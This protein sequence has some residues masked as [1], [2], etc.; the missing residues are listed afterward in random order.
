MNTKKSL[1]ALLASVM[2]VTMAGLMTACTNEDNASNANVDNLA[3]KIIG[4]WIG[5]DMDGQEMMTNEKRVVTFVSATKAYVSA[6][7][8]MQDI[9][10]IWSSSIEASVAIDGNKMTVI[11][12]PDELTTVEEEFTVTAIDDNEFTANCK[13]TRTVDGIEQ[14]SGIINVRHTKVTADYSQAIVGIWE[15]HCTSANSVFDDGQEHRWEYRADGSYVYYCKDAN[16]RWEAKDAVISQ[17]FV[18]GNLLCTRWQNIGEN[19]NRE[20]WEISIDGNTMNWTALRQNDD[21]TT[22][23]A[24][25]TM[26]KV[27]DPGVMWP[28]AIDETYFPDEVFRKNLLEYHDKDQDGKLSV[29]EMEKT[30]KVEMNGTGL[31]SLKGIELFSELNFLRIVGGELTSVDVSKNTKLKLLHILNNQLTD[32]DVSHNPVLGNIDLSNNQLTKIDIS[33]N[34]E[35]FLL[36][37]ADNKVSSIDLSNNR[38]IK[39]LNVGNNLLTELDVTGLSEMY[40]C[41]CYGNQLTTLDVTGCD[42][43]MIFTIYNNRIKGD[44]MTALINSMPTVK[45]G[46]FEVINKQNG[47]EQNVI[48]DEQIAAAQAKGWTVEIT[49]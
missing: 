36:D 49:E 48:T 32:I 1:F 21:G 24:T 6:S 45:S 9:E 5:T 22:F 37:I 19:E 7:L 46:T 34:P 3:E 42:K 41:G 38:K 26:N 25:F 35:L 29:A 16:G 12:H 30:E 11:S 14:S 33:K 2:L 28:V 10:S 15:G 44:G 47:E 4:K 27:E 17:Y 20:W 18:D 8:T 23:T 13:L 39:Q 40:F 43:L 31:K